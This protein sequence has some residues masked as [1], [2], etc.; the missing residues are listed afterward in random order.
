M[1]RIG[2]YMIDSSTSR[3]GRS[4]IV[5][6]G[7][8]TLGLFLG[9]MA[10]VILRAP[11]LVQ[12][13]HWSGLATL[14]MSALVLYA[15][16]AVYFM[17]FYVMVRVI[18]LIL[19][20]KLTASGAALITALTAIPF[21][22]VQNSLQTR[23]LGPF[24]TLTSPRFYVPTAIMLGVLVGVLVVL[25]LIVRRVKE[26]PTWYR[27]ITDWRSL[28]AIAFVVFI[29]Y[30][31]LAVTPMNVLGMFTEEQERDQKMQYRADR[32]QKAPPDAPN[33]I[34]LKIEA[35]RWDEFTPEN[36]PFLWQ[37]RTTSGFPTT[38]LWHRPPGLRSRLSSPRS[39]RFSI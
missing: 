24:M 20:L 39:T 17:L 7:A 23:L 30:S 33:F 27:R 8:V 16:I 28:I 14:A 22:V 1:Q 37:L 18:M 4:P 34:V 5:L 29:A 9:E 35:F 32:V 11:G 15:G 31:S 3:L 36:A 13:A 12:P 25:D 26:A 6:L 21:L 19:R 10:T 38:T 2:G